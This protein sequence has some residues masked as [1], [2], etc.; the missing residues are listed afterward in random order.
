MTGVPDFGLIELEFLE[1]TILDIT[2]AG[3]DLTCEDQDS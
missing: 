2:G 1:E 3:D